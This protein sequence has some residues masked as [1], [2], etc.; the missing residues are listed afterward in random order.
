M[1]R[2]TSQVYGDGVTELPTSFAP[3]ERA[4]RQQVERSIA[5]LLAEPL[6]QAMLDAANVSVVVLNR[7]RQIIVANATLLQEL[8]LSGPALAEGLRPGELLDCVYAWKSPGGCGTSA[9]CASCGAAL[10]VLTSQ[11]SD[12][13]VERECLMTVEREG[14]IGALEL[15]VRASPVKLDGQKFTVVALR[16]ISAEKRREALERVFLHDLSNTVGGLLGWSELLSQQ[17]PPPLA[18][19][20]ERIHALAQRLKHE[21]EGQR[22][23]VQ[24]ERGT[25]QTVRGPVHPTALLKSAASLLDGHPSARARTV[26]IG[27]DGEEQ[28][29]V[30]DATLLVRVLVNMLKN[31]L[32]AT[33][34]GGT[35]R[36]WAERHPDRCELRVWNAGY[37][38]PPVATQIFRRSFSTKPGPGRGLG[39]FSMKFFVE[40]YLGGT[41]GFTSDET[42]GTTFFVCLPA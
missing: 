31:A 12:S 19:A 37:I 14:G 16:D 38:P 33:P 34:E 11:Q 41:V 36:A 13:T 26:Q 4:T 25:L 10:A 20:T 42:A 30:T 21:I 39:T 24:A 40:R 22:L 8:Q 3:S 15:S 2:L 7:Q 9:E 27:P 18:G 29:L 17:A 28:I 6:I 32:E 23:L 1:R 5:T 35:V